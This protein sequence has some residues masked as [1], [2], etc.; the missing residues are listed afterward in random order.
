MTTDIQGE[1]A[2]HKETSKKENQKRNLYK[3][4]DK[5]QNAQYECD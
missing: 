5:L 4:A 1:K 2:M 3:M